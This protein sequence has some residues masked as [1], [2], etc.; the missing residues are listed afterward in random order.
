MSRLTTPF[1]FALMLSAAG[2]AL[3]QEAISSPAA[4]QPAL[5]AFKLN[6]KLIWER[7]GSDPSPHDRRVDR[8]ELEQTLAAGLS[9]NVSA[10]LK[11]PV[12]WQGTRRAHGPADSDSGLA[13]PSLTLKWRFWQHDSAAVDTARLSLLVGT[14]LPLGT[15]AFS[16]RAFDPTVGLAFTSISGRHGFGAAARWTFTTRAK[17]DP[18]MLGETLAD[19]LRLDGSY[20]YRLAPESW[21]ADTAAAWY[22]VGEVNARIETTGM[23]EVLLQPGILYEATRFAAEL[24]L[25]L[26][27]LHRVDDRPRTKLVLTAGVRWLF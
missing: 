4:T 23:H 22:L 6:Q 7:R 10:E 19:L 1:A 14:D 13:D 25:G 18:M 26:P 12:L 3:A 5:G 17:P 8:L 21:S 16:N 2:P 9:G 20:L 27:V 15:R 11:L 24:G